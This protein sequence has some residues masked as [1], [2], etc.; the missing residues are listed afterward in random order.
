M[1]HIEYRNLRTVSRLK[2]AGQLVAGKTEPLRETMQTL[3]QSSSVVMDLSDVT[4]M[5]AHGLSLL[6]Q[7]REQAQASG[8]TFQVVNV[9]DSLRELFRITRLY[10]VFQLE[11]DVELLPETA[12]DRQT[13][14]AA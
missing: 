12:Q 4:L 2:L 1:L 8:M 9:K 10:S 6:L 14:M 5:D 13:R 7:L 3:P 11:H